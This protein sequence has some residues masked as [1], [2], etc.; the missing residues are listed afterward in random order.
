MLSSVVHKP[1]EAGLRSIQGVAMT[2]HESTNNKNVISI[3]IVA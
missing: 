3:C 2:A 1:H